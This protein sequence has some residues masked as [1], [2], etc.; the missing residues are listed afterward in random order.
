MTRYSASAEEYSYNNEEESVW[1][2]SK[3]QE[4]IMCDLWEEMNRVER[5]QCVSERPG[6]SNTDDNNT[7]QAR[8]TTQ[9]EGESCAVRVRRQT[10]R[11]KMKILVV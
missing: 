6:R 11:E 7:V 5:L 4:H 3:T 9:C 2:R 1:A 10:Q 8:C